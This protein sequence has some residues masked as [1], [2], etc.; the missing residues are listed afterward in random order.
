MNPY[1]TYEAMQLLTDGSYA[2]LPSEITFNPL[3]R[4]FKAKKCVVGDPDFDLDND[5]DDELGN[6]KMP[7]TKNYD[8]VVIA[9][10]TTDTQYFVDTSNVFTLTITP[11]CLADT[12]QLATDWD[13]FDYFVTSAN[14][15]L[16]DLVPIINQ[17]IV[18]CARECKLEEWGWDDE[19]PNPPVIYFNG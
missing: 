15:E 3:T 11:N 7:Y 2:P 10:L 6:M 17:Q 9:R 8:L 18:T 13:T 5:C 1:F 12:L 19:Y 4:A 14:P 16:L